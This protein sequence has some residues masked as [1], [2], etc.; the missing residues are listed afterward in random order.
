MN[1]ISTACIIDDDK[2][3]I[4]TLKKM[5][6]HVNFCSNFM[7]FNNG[8]EAVKGLQEISEKKETLPDLIFLDLNMPIMDGWDYL[9]EI[10]DHS[11]IKNIRT[12]IVTSSIDPVDLDK[13][14][15]FETVTSYIT[16]PLNIKKL[17]ELLNS[18]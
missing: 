18:L 10:K 7:V 14:K 2:I 15:T 11:T 4:Y 1:K 8:L 13:T 5:M 6:E 12:Y 16:K 3:F 9:E 17:K